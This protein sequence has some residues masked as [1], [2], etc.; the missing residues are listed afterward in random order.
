MHESCSYKFSPHVSADWEQ[1]RWQDSST[2]AP[3]WCLPNLRPPELIGGARHLSGGRPV[4]QQDKHN[5]HALEGCPGSFWECNACTCLVM[6][7]QTACWLHQSMVIVQDNV[8]RG[9]MHKY[10]SL[11]Y[12]LPCLLPL[13]WSLGLLIVCS[14][15]APA[16]PTFASIP[17]APAQ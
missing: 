3:A 8:H 11:P 4:C 15:S 6:S 10:L 14:I 9:W 17:R 12:L 2:K 1:Q 13:D 16:H 5:Q 7:L